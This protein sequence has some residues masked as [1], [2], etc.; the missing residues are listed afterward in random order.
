MVKKM[1]KKSLAMG[2]QAVIEGVMIK[3]TNF[4]VVAARKGKKIVYKEDKNKKR[5]GILHKLPVI[6]GFYNLIDMLF[7]GMR[8]LMWSAN[9]QLEEEKQEKISR[10]E[11]FLTIAIS[12]GVAIL[13]FVALPYFLT[14][15]A[16][17]HE[18]T[19]PFFFNLI[20]GIIRISVFLLYIFAISMMKDIQT[21]FRYHGAEH[22]S[23]HCYERK[24]SLTSANV[25]K[26][27]T[28]H[29]R[30]GTAFIMIVLVASILVFSVVTPLIFFIFP[31]IADIDLVPRKII[32]F[33]IRLS[34]IPI[35]AGLSY[36]FLKYSAKYE[37]NPVMRFLIM[38]GLLMQKITTKKPSKMQIEVALAAVKRSI[39]LEKSKNI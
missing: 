13:I 28:L 14:I 12:M 22:M 9:Q 34:L 6:R 26:F 27:S 32:L 21:L 4:T 36:E 15:F 19:Q 20:D 11:I 35:I 10:K 5:T 17:F 31:G 18:E 7:L 2:G 1:A 29:P 39:K 38:P 24:K 23:I 8:A 16:G 37:K 3:S 30:C 33:F 25:S